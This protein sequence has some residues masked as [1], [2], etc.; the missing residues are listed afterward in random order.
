ML[1]LRQNTGYCDGMWSFV[2]GHVEDGEPATTGMIREAYEEIGIQLI[3]SQI[4]VVHVMHRKTTRLN[5][6]IF[7]DCQSW[8]GEIQN[9]EPEK[10]AGLEFFSLDELPSSMIDYNAVALKSIQRGEFYSEY[11]WNEN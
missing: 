9:K 3:P 11:G 8:C 2:A 7:F 1:Q 5:V 6:D 10:C 4:K